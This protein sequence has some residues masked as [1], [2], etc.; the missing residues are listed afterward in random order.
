MIRN[1]TTVVRFL[2]AA[3]AAALVL[4]QLTGCNTMHGAGK[5][6]ERAGEK[7]QEEAD[8]HR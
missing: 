6:I 2:L 3:A 5:D 8:E 4:P 1:E 7:I